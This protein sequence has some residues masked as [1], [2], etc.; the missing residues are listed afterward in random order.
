MNRIWQK[1]FGAGIVRSVDYFGTRG[2]KPSHPELLDALAAQFMREGW[3]Q[4]RL[5]RSLVLSHAYRLSSES[6]GIASQVDAE[7]RLL[8]RMN[9][10]RL[11]AEALRDSLN[12][13]AGVLVPSHGG[14]A[15]PL[16]YP[17]NSSSLRPQA[18]NPPAFALR[19]FRPEQEF[20]RTI[21]LPVIRSAQPG[22]A[23]L[24][25]VFDFT[26][27]AQMAGQ[28]PQTVVP[29]QAL[30]LLNSQ[31]VRQRADALATVL[32]S[33]GLRDG[34]RLEQLWLRV[35]S[36]PITAEEYADAMAFLQRLHGMA[37]P[38]SDPALVAWVELCHSV[39]SSNEFLHRL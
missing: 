16:E 36:R 25:D 2:A 26:Q 3:S 20:Q 33:Q 23:R 22:P 39:L 29:T 10:Q 37:I 6:S 14:P 34:E 11:D 7:N 9:G 38:T 1:L 32:L 21:Y 35:L 17:E 15:L 5:I 13:V 8:W 31:Q 12:A 19:R 24:R 4:K 28:R 18:V 30:F 27:P